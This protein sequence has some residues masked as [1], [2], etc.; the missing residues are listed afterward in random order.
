MSPKQQPQY[1][2]QSQGRSPALP[3][4]LRT[5]TYVYTVLNQNDQIRHS[6][7]FR[8]KHVFRS[9][10]ALHMA[11]T[12]VPDFL[13]PQNLSTRYGIEQPNSWKVARVAEL[14]IRSIT[15]PH[16]GGIRGKKSKLTTYIR[17]VWRKRMLTR[18][19]FAIADLL[20]QQSMKRKHFN[21]YYFRFQ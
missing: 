21:V 9:N 8:E 5:L 17:T 16:Y 3:I 15:P 20:I 10:T 1:A 14:S 2:P 13:D 7:P 18:D 11:A 4:F 6:N 12:S 19:L